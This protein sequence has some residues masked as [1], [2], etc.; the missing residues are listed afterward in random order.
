LKDGSVIVEW[1]KPFGAGCEK[2]FYRIIYDDKEIK[3]HDTQ[4]T[5]S[6]DGTV[7]EQTYNLEVQILSSVSSLYNPVKLDF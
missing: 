2:P 1:D 7:G 4:F 3:R 5:L 6:N